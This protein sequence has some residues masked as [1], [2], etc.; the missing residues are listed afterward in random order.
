[1]G[2]VT[3]L[4]LTGGI[5]S[6]KSTAAAMLAE[7]GAHVVDA[8]AIARSLTAAG[9]AAVHE[10]GAQLGAQFVDAAGGLDRSVMRAA[11]FSDPGLRVRLEAIV[12][13]LVRQAIEREIENPGSTAG[14]VVIDVP[15]LFETMAYRGMIN[16]AVAVDCARDTQIRRVRQRSGLSAA[17]ADAIVTAQ[18]SRPLRLQLADAVLCNDAG[19]DSLRAQVETLQGHLHRTR[20]T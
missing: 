14:I 18:I 16:L 5:G 20:A 17:E 3:L 15:L 4:G 19:L 6:G 10:I 13:P 9:G 8:D 11:A 1:M 12:H 7:G 2:G